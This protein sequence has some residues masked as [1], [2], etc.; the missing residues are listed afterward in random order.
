MDI[1]RVWCERVIDLGVECL[2]TQMCAS[3]V[4]SKCYIACAPNVH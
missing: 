2:H 4:E 1:D 3:C